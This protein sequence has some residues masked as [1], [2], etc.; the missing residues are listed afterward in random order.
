MS[1]NA[2]TEVLASP[3]GSPDRKL[4]AFKLADIADEDGRHIE[5]S[6]PEIARQADMTPAAVKTI[7][8]AFCSE[9]LLTDHG[10]E[11]SLNM[12]MLSR[13]QAERNP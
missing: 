1:I 4:V 10:G 5:P 9:G 11:Y 2:I 7:I 12:A 3:L 8:K 13:L 6:I